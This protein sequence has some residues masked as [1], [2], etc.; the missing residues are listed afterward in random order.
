MDR[1]MALF[2]VHLKFKFGSINNEPR[3]FKWRYYFIHTMNSVEDYAKRLAKSE[4]EN[5]DTL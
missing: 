5:L 4:K 2:N 3:P 1:D